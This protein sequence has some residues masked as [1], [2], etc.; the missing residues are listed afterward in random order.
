MNLIGPGGLNCPNKLILGT[1]NELISSGGYHFM[2]CSS[3]G[4]FTYK[5]E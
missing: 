3:M 1:K 2:I 5:M 4:V